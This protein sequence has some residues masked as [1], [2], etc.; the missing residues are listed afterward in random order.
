MAMKLMSL[1]CGGAFR[2]QKLAMTIFTVGHAICS[3]EAMAPPI[4]EEFLEA[5][6]PSTFL[7]ESTTEGRI[8]LAADTSQLE[9][10][11]VPPGIFIIQGYSGSNRM[12]GNYYRCD[13]TV[14]LNRQAMVLGRSV[15]TEVTFAVYESDTSGGLYS[16]LSTSTVIAG[17]GTNLVESGE[18]NITLIAGKYYIIGASWNQ[19]VYYRS[20][21]AHPAAT[22]FGQTLNGYTSNTYPPAP[23]APG[24]ANSLLYP[25]QLTFSTNMVVRM[26]DS[27]DS[28]LTSTN[29]MHL[30][31]DL[32][33]YTDVS[34][35]FRHREAG[36]EPHA[37]DGV[38][39]S[40]DGGTTFTRIYDLDVASTAWQD[41]TLDIDA[42]AAANALAL[43]G[44]VVLS[45]QQ[46]DNYGWPTDGREFD[47][48]RIYSKVDLAA[49]SL[50]LSGGSTVT[51]TWKGFSTPKTVAVAGSV[52]GT[53]TLN[54]SNYPAVEFGYLLEDSASTSVYYDSDVQAWFFAGMASTTG[55]LSKTI[56]MPGTLKLTDN[57]YTLSLEADAGDVVD[58]ALEGNNLQALNL[59]VNHYSGRLWFDSV[60]AD[61]TVKKWTAAS[62][63]DHR[64]TGTG[65][66]N[67]HAFSFT[68]Y[69]V[70]KNLTTL[71]YSV[72][73]ANATVIAVNTPG[74]KS[75]AGVSFWLPDGI[76]MGFSGV[77]GDVEV[78]LP[79]GLGIKGDTD[80]VMDSR[81]VFSMAA[82]A[83]GL[84][85]SSAVTDA[86]PLYIS[87]ETKPLFFLVDDISWDPSLGRFTFTKNDA[88]FVRETNLAT[89]ESYV[90]DLA[91][92]TM[93]IKRSNAQYYR[94]VDSMLENITVTTAGDTS[95]RMNTA[96]G[97]SSGHVMP[98]F[99]YGPDQVWKQPSDVV[100]REDLINASSQLVEME[101]VAVQYARA[102]AGNSC[103]GG[104][105]P[106]SVVGYAIADSAF[107]LDG[108]I[109]QPVGLGINLR[110]G[111]RHDG[112][113][114]Q[115]AVD[116]IDGIY[117]MPGH[118]L[119]GD[120]SD[121]ASR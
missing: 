26:D 51:N 62:K 5:T 10:D 18:M 93:I 32:A 95:A 107:S 58:E 11:V 46:V 31:L 67:G 117:Y 1:G 43:N 44:S 8:E 79:A 109:R 36:D 42:L 105:G 12:R 76:T 102:C 66:I 69:R 4:T 103:S 39:L 119:R 50:A 16:L 61:I 33:G 106:Q 28:S 100:I 56:S 49:E 38:F 87:E 57:L 86:G 121:L 110:W 25:Q 20:G 77:D 65:T 90:T 115:E 71:D 27:V 22:G 70:L 73:P 14:S 85:P 13:E 41:V 7:Y 98:H 96:V 97:L 99:P 15:S 84:Y 75:V 35:R 72:H 52:I 114:A 53:G 118:F 64:I 37:G 60:E 17:I 116:F 3:V 82:L 120:Q 91:D 78:L 81:Y 2:L 6:L 9:T 104:A 24:A 47:D 19:T 108:G 34:L 30:L 111:V 88:V 80:Y 113:Y 112:A 29:K 55:N 94:Y 21:G 59:A 40:D 68:N 74:R 45:F 63:T 83:Q 54:D 92:P 23:T 101:D 89:L 48:I